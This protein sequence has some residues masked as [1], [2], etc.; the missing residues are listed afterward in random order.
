MYLHNDRDEDG[1]PDALEEHIGEGLKDGVR[2]EE[3][4]EG[5]VVPR[6][7]HTQVPIEARDL[8]VPN[9]CP[10]QEGEKV[11]EAELSVSVFR[12]SFGIQVRDIW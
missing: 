1:G 4:G 6:R 7:V 2:D 8:G 11:E 10:V 12:T 5:R 9:V 3:D